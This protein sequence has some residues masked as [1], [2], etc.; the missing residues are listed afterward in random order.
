MAPYI[1]RS[2]FLAAAFGVVAQAATS[3]WEPGLT[4]I[5]SS[6]TAHHPLAQNSAAAAQHQD[7][8]KA[9][10]QGLLMLFGLV[11]GMSS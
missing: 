6:D 10:P 5:R 1:V 9:N 2:L 11:H 3:W 8:H 7:R 4:I